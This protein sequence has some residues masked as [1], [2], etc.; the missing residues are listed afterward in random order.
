MGESKNIPAFLNELDCYIYSS[1]NDSFGI[2]VIEAMYVGLPVIVSNNGPFMELTNNGKLAI[3][4]E[5][6][7]DLDFY[8]KVDEYLKNPD[9][10]KDLAEESQTICT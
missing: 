8:N 2:S 1:Q 5:C 4:F 7:N 9:Y 6:K 10:Y 3:L